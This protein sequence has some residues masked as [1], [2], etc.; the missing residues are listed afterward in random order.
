[1]PLS[2]SRKQTRVFLGIHDGSPVL[3]ITD[4]G[5]LPGVNRGCWQVPP[6]PRGPPGA[7]S[8]YLGALGTLSPPSHPASA[9]IRVMPNEHGISSP[10]C[11]GKQELC[12]LPYSRYSF[13]FSKLSLTLPEPLC[14][15]HCPALNPCLRSYTRRT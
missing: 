12:I 7:P 3:H 5:P 4:R 8:P 14:V 15:P 6:P 11:F 9:I 13:F 2:Q 1:M 10:G